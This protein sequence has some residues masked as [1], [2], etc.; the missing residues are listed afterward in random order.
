M[1][2]EERKARIVWDRSFASRERARHRA[3]VLGRFLLTALLA[4]VFVLL[5]LERMGDVP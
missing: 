1:T 3:A 2:P 4:V 5:V